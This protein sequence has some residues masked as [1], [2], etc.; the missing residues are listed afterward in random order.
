LCFHAHAQEDKGRRDGN[1]WRTIDTPSKDAYMVGFF[2]GILLGER[3]SYWKFINK[4]GTENSQTAKVIDSFKTYYKLLQDTT[5]DQFRDGL[6]K[7]YGDYRNRR[8]A[9]TD[10]VWI[11]INTIAGKSDKEMEVIILNSRKS[12][13]Q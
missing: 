12:A 9:V 5:N 11:V 1:W 7:F 10:A 8:I 6:D 13:G 2:D 3:F 4:D